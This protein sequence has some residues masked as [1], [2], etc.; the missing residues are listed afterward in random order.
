MTNIK[1]RVKTSWDRNST[2]LKGL[3]NFRYHH[4]IYMNVI[5]HLKGGST[6]L[7]FTR[8]ISAIERFT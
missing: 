1:E 7:G 2:L 6:P 8:R 3:L 4:R 5:K